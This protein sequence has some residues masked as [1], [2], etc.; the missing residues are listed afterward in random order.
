M[1]FQLL[2]A[3][4]LASAA[5]MSPAHASLV[6]DSSLIVSAEGFGN[7]HR[8]LTVQANGTESGC[9]SSTSGGTLIGGADACLDSDATAGNGVINSGG[10]EPN[11]L[12]DNQKYGIPTLG[13]LN[14]DSASDV[15]I[16]FNASE[17]LNDDGAINL[18]D[19]TLKFMDGST[20]LLALDGGQPFDSSDPGN[21]SA[22]FVF[23]IEEDMWA[24]VDSLIFG[25]DGFESFRIALEATLSGAGGGPDTFR[26]LGA[27][28]G[29]IPVPE[30]AAI[31]LLGLGLAGLGLARRR[32]A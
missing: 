25:A 18:L 20:V 29:G 6:Y 9:V 27:D 8:S 15:R 31:G 2:A 32:K 17:P 7:A 16:I 10:N 13:E 28:G 3:S 24:L 12:S 19:L 4:V 1:R 14:Y 21:G 23:V 5:L 22:G 26:I 30:P 11:P